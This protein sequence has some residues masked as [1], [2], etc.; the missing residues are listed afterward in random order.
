MEREFGQSRKNFIIEATFL[1]STISEFG[2]L[3]CGILKMYYL[4]KKNIITRFKFKGLN[5][6]Q[7]KKYPR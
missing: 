5:D 3:I 2:Q 4:A 7:S 6:C 1:H